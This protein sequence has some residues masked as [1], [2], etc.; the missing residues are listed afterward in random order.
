[1]EQILLPLPWLHFLLEDDTDVAMAPAPALLYTFTRRVDWNA[2][3]RWGK[4]VVIIFGI[5][6]GLLIIEHM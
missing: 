1:M 3:D 6:V 2:W 4:W 5:L